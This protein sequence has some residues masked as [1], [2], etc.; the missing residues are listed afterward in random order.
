M[1]LGGTAR[2]FG[3]SGMTSIHL[4]LNLVEVSSYLCLAGSLHSQQVEGSDDSPLFG[5]L[6]SIAGS[7][8]QGRDQQVG[9]GPVKSARHMRKG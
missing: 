2:L 7:L 1:V 5:T 8:V 9:P 6:P 3:S 4:S